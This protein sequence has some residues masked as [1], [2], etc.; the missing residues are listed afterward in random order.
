LEGF[1]LSEAVQAHT[2]RFV[3]GDIELPESIQGLAHAD[4]NG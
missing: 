3:N 2:T 4:A 1:T